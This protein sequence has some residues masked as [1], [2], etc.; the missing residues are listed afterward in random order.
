M[1][2]D[3]T[4]RPIGVVSGGRDDWHEDDW[5]SV[6]AA[7]VL[8][9][10]QFAPDA[11]TGLHEF[12]HVEV[13]FLFDRV[14]PS[15]IRSEPRPARGDNRFPPVGV[16]AHRGPFRPNRIG[17]TRCRLLDVTGLHL[18]VQGLDA[19]AGSPVLDVKPCHVEFE[20]GPISQPSW[21]SQLMADYF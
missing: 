10:E 13:V 9:S 8:D 19:L 4:L 21:T 12:S 15:R 11:T 6:E 2:D 14:D 20:T 1:A 7:I 3:V 17:V 18:R 16:F 5:G